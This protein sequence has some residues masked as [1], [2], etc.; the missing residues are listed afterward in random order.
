MI[1][2]F[3]LLRDGTLKRTQDVEEAV[4]L[5]EAAEEGWRLWLDLESPAEEEF[6]ILKALFQFHPLTLET[7]LSPT[8]SPGIEGFQEYMFLLVSAVSFENQAE[9]VETTELVCYLGRNYLVTH[10][11][12]PLQ[13][14]QEAKVRCLKQEGALSRGPDYLL[15]IILQGVVASFEPALDRLEEAI[16]A[17]ETEILNRPRPSS[18]R[19]LLWAR[20]ETARLQRI[21]QGQKDVYEQIGQKGS[22]H[23]S[24]SMGFDFGYLSERMADILRRTEAYQSLITGCLDTYQALLSSRTAGLVR[25]LAVLAAIVFPLSLIGGIVWINLTLRSGLQWQP[26]AW[27]ALGLTGFLAMGI[28]LFCRWRGWL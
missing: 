26:K 20:K 2:T 18:L 3:L 10:H 24:P 9:A 28:L 15:H 14:I 8:P 6:G 27:T 11:R 19:R 4:R 22:S 23:I 5:V 12:K 1:D 7:C 17:S 13:P 16:E 21:A 25:L